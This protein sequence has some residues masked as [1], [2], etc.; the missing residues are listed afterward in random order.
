MA[1]TSTQTFLNI[2]H[3]L[4]SLLYNNSHL[5]RRLEQEHFNFLRFMQAL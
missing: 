1:K 3:N 4:I 2:K 5:V